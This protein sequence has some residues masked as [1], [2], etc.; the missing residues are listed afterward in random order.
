MNKEFDVFYDL[1]SQKFVDVLKF[2][3]VQDPIKVAI[4][5][6]LGL[7]IKTM[8]TE[9]T[10]DIVKP[11]VHVVLNLLSKTGFNYTLFGQKFGLGKIIEQIIVFVLFLMVLYYG[12]ILPIDNLRKKYNI[13]QKT[14][15]CPYCT[16][17]ISPEAT[18]C[19]ACTSQLKT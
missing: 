6:A 4:G 14:T 8:F 1:T 11:F 3:L 13:E 15:P 7:S 17:L 18:R 9:V 16:T 10:D 19:P 2:I 12:F 5:M